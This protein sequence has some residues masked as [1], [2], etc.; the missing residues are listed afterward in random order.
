MYEYQSCTPLPPRTIFD[1]GA[2]SFLNQIVNG[3][4]VDHLLALLQLIDKFGLTP[5]MK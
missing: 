1:V 2:L 3:V 5:P 4:A